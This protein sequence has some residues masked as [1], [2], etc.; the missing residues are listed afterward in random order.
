MSILGILQYMVSRLD[1]VVQIADFLTG[2]HPVDAVS[3]CHILL[4]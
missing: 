3:A 4:P 1:V 2:I